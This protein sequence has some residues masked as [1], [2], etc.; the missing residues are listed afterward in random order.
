MK[1]FEK[2]IQVNSECKLVWNSLGYAY[3]RLDKIEKAIECY[4]K[5]LKVDPNNST[6]LI[7][8]GNVYRRTK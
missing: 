2:Y 1:W 4:N 6:A 7:N 8:L 3:E 5:S